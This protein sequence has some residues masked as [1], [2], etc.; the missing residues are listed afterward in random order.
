MKIYRWLETYEPPWECG[1]GCCSGGGDYLYTYLETYDTE[2]DTV[3]FEDGVYPIS[4]DSADTLFKT[5][6]HVTGIFVF[7]KYKYPAGDNENVWQEGYREVV[8]AVTNELNEM[9]VGV[10]IICKEEDNE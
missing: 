8:R 7:C 6:E 4:S 1:D 10:E 5:Y 9:D 2:T 3:V